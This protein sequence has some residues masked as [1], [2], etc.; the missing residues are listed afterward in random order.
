MKM[1]TINNNSKGGYAPM[2]NQKVPELSR[3]IKQA[4]YRMTVGRETILK[5]L[6]ATTDHLSAED[7]YLRTH[8]VNPSIGLT[9]V[10]RTLDLLVDIGLIQKFDF[11]D[12]RARF[13]MM[14]ETKGANHHHHLVCMGCG[15]VVDY[16]DFMNLEVKFL[17]R[18]ERKLSKKYKFK[19]TNHL[20]QYY[21]TCAK[22]GT[23]KNDGRGK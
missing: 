19:I 12:G 14:E 1:V 4:G 5:L 2:N 13:E 15:R 7:I 10:Y 11:G 6:S 22:C 16:S 23:E 8:S 20:V 17:K 18:I 3:R 21:G 9:S